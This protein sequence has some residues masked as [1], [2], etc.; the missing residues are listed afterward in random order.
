MPNIMATLSSLAD[1]LHLS[2]TNT[3]AGEHLS[4]PP[5]SSD[6]DVTGMLE[7]LSA[8]VPALGAA[9]APTG[10]APSLAQPLSPG[11]R[12]PS[13]SLS[14]LGP[15]LLQLQEQLQVSHDPEPN[16]KHRS[17][18][19]A[20][21]AALQRSAPQEDVAPAAPD[22]TLLSETVSESLH[23]HTHT[24]DA[25]APKTSPVP[26]ITPPVSEATPAPSM[27]PRMDRPDTSRGPPGHPGPPRIMPG[28]P[29]PLPPPP[30][31][32][33]TRQPPLHHVHQHDV[34][35]P[36][37]ATSGDGLRGTPSRPPSDSM[38]TSTGLPP[39]FA[40]VTARHSHLS[41]ALSLFSTAWI[42]QPH[43]PAPCCGWKYLLT[44]AC[45]FQ[46]ECMFVMR[47]SLG[48]GPPSHLCGRLHSPRGDLWHPIKA[49]HRHFLRAGHHSHRLDHHSTVPPL[50]GLI[51]HNCSRQLAQ[52]RAHRQDQ[53]RLRMTPP[54]CQTVCIHAASS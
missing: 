2:S 13:G 41:C 12:G 33:N 30:L 18:A 6:V 32:P 1:T 8:A 3:G 46:V 49:G 42:A 31:P 28:Q 4:A 26:P 14:G 5:A 50:H 16:A 44:K 19:A 38:P 9:S 53:S 11:G 22:F 52:R 37:A 10:N 36:L 51:P 15:Q 48:H 34:R 17:A 39:Q 45:A 43:H 29:H 20:I 40:K 54:L 24:Q 7:S 21:A 27:K 25:P 47:Q 35:A 23:K